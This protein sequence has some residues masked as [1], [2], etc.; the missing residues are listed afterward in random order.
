MY[1]FIYKNKV[2]YGIGFL[3]VLLILKLKKKA[4]FSSTNFETSLDTN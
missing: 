2:L 4:P 3:W 1:R